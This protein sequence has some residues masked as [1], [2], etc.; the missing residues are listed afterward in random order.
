MKT[1]NKI[2]IFLF[3]VIIALVGTVL[4]MSK[5]TENPNEYVYNNFRIFKN[6]TVGYTILAYL[7]EQP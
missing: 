7:E 5:P 4:L 2:A 3:L 6:P 1:E